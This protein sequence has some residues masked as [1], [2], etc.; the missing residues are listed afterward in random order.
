MTGESDVEHTN[1]CQ[2]TPVIH[3]QAAKI[4]S[5]HW[6]FSVP[7][8]VCDDVAKCLRQGEHQLVVAQHRSLVFQRLERLPQSTLLPCLAIH[9][10]L[11][12]RKSETLR[13]KDY[14]QITFP[15]KISSPKCLPA[16]HQMGNNITWMRKLSI[17]TGQN[18]RLLSKLSKWGSFTPNT[19]IPLKVDP[20]SHDSWLIFLFSNWNLRFIGRLM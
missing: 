1:H 17:P 5:P 11:K 18:F 15:T 2:K 12:Y 8:L 6:S 20:S 13:N 9:K 4:L 14:Q 19:V 16:S 3:I 7:C 10:G